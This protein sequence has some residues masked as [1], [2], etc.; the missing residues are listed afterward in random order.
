MRPY[1][2]YEKYIKYTAFFNSA[3]IKNLLPSYIKTLN[4]VLKQTTQICHTTQAN[5]RAQLDPLIC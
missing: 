2:R 1:Y 5:F 4:D 3:E